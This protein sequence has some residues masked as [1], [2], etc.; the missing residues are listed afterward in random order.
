MP[1]IHRRLY[2]AWCR[3][4]GVHL[5]FEEVIDLLADD[6]IATV[7][8]DEALQE[9]GLEPEGHDQLGGQPEASWKAFVAKLK[10]D[11]S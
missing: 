4:A 6:A 9:A 5:A 2:S 8:T 7:V 11:R 3:G 1:S 10:N